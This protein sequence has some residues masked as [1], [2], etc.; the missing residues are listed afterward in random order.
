MKQRD[1]LGC[2]ALLAALSTAAP[3]ACAQPMADPTRPPPGVAESVPRLE[4]VRGPVLQSIMITQQSRSAII[5]GQRVE[6]GGR[7]GDARVVKI[8]DNEI[9]LRSTDGT[10]VLKLSP[11]VEMKAVTSVHQAPRKPRREKN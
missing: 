2:V 5:N 10:E 11:D 7:Y 9:V 6:L 4:T 1:L 3:V 8:D